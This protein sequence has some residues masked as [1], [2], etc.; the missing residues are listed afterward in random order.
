MPGDIGILDETGR[1]YLKGRERD[2]INKDGM[3]VY[4]ADVEA[5]VEQ[6]SQTH[7]VCVFWVR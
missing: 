4:P 5:V 2:E 6:F 7:D 3:K 1:L